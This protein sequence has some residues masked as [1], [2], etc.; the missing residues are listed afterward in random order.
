MKIVDRRVFE[1]V[2]GHVE[3]ALALAIAENLRAFPGR[4]RVYL[5]ETGAVGRI[6]FEWEYASLAECEQAWTEW[7]NDPEDA[8]FLKRWKVLTEQS[9][10]ELLTLVESFEGNSLTE[11]LGR[12]VERVG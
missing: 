10:R 11:D 1:V 9:A 4:S 3:E 6:V 5:T 8:A 2:R 12:Q 7:R